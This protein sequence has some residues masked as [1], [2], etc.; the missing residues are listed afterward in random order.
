MVWPDPGDDVRVRADELAA[1]GNRVLMLANRDG[2]LPDVTL[3]ADELPPDLEPVAL[4]TFE[5]RLREDAAET[6]E[7]FTRQS[8][9]LKVISGDNPRTVGAVAARVGL[10]SADR[11]FDA[12]ELPEDEEELADIVETHA[13]FGRVSP[14]QKRHIINALQSRG[15]TVAMTGDGVN[16]ALALKDADIGI[17]M[18]NGAAATRAVAQIVLLD[19]DFATMPGIV[20]EGR[21]VIANVERVA[22]LFVTKTVYAVC[23]AFAVGVARWPYPFLP[24]HLTIVSSV[25]IGIPAFL[26]ALAPNAAR[27]RP[28]FVERVLRFALPAGV[29][30]ASATFVAYWLVRNRN[31]VSL[32]ESRTSATIVLLVV[33]LA[34]LALL[35]RPLT[36]AAIALVAAMAVG[37]GMLFV[38]PA[39]RDFYALGLPPAH[40]L[41]SAAAV[42]TIGVFALEGWWIIDQRS[43]PPAD[44]TPTF[45]RRSR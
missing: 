13:V 35:A 1:S 11:V 18:G 8:V 27:S 2:A 36:P 45:A 12:R 3:S 31:H 24:R 19:S 32:N 41:V 25:T 22:N 30:V 21:R 10:P 37:V 14:R 5:E 33:G 6:L 26:L 44:R 28:G 15:H 20:A 4:V 29:I 17:A 38:V 40:A 9:T 7:Y 39:T 43:R 34:V 23:L 42:A 16:D